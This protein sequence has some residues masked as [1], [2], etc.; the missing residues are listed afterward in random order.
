MI[1]EL[2]S[3]TTKPAQ[4]M[5]YLD[6]FRTTGVHLITRHLPMLGYWLGETG[7]LNTIHHMWAYES[8]EERAAKRVH[9]AKDE[10]WNKGF[11]EKAFEVVV[12]QR[13]CF[14]TLEQGTALLDSKVASR[15]KVHAQET[16]E[17]PTFANSWNLITKSPSP[18]TVNS[19]TFGTWNVQI[20]DKPGTRLSI[21]SLSNVDQFLTNPP[22][23]G[24]PEL[25]RP[26]AV[27]PIQ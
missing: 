14:M 3:Y 22:S 10:E 18:E 24:T 23:T 26:M 8:F 11:I 15:N 17:M 9:V 20:G 21:S 5:Y 13:T 1:Y 2:R 27:S 6:L 7:Q 19:A 16:P 25:I 4:A 12:S